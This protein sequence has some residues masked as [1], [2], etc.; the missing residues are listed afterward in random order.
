METSLLQTVYDL[1]RSNLKNAVFRQ[2]ELY[3]Q[4]IHGKPYAVGDLVW[5]C[6]QCR[7]QAKKLFVHGGPLEGNQEA[8]QCSLQNSRH[9][10][11][12]KETNDAF[13]VKAMH[14]MLKPYISKKTTGEL[15]YTDVST[16]NQ[17]NT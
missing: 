5:L 1:A 10:K 15:K 8:E 14:F 16:S 7:G 3:D 2:K 9:S 11:L 17:F 4:K 13:Y 12:T 6:S